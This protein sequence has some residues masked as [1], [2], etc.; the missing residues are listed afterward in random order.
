MC[1]DGA[2]V[3]QLQDVCDLDG[4]ECLLGTPAEYVEHL[5]T[6]YHRIR[7]PTSLHSRGACS[8]RWSTSGDGCRRDSVD[9][10][11][12]L[13]LDSDSLRI[14]LRQPLTQSRHFGGKGDHLIE[15]FCHSHVFQYVIVTQFCDRI[16]DFLDRATDY[17]VIAKDSFDAVTNYYVIATEFYAITTSFYVTARD[18]YVTA[19]D[20]YVTAKDSYVTAKDSYVI[21]TDPLCHRERLLCH[22]DRLLCHR[23]RLLRHRERL[24]CPSRQTSMSSRQISM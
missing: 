14:E 17:Y 13:S 12:D 6:Q 19:K 15:I 18:S 3:A 11:G 7:P 9:M 24:L 10:V 4:G 23:E 5:G 20:S 2:L 21:A 8:G 16:T 1:A 22:R